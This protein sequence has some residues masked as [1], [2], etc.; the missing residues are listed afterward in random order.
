MALVHA[1]VNSA[2]RMEAWERGNDTRAIASKIFG[3]NSAQVINVVSVM[4]QH[5][6][7][8]DS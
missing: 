4:D 1:L 8:Q 5:R 7:G 2:R 3:P 6:L